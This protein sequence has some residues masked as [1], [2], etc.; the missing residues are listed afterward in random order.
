MGGAFTR[1]YMKTNSN[2]TT[3]LYLKVATEAWIKG[4][5]LH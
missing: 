5:G 1:F 4:L 3:G 2:F